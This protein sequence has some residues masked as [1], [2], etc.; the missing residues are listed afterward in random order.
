MLK[1][2]LNS[3]WEEEKYM[4]GIETK[5]PG[6]A[7]K[8]IPLSWVGGDGPPR[9]CLALQLCPASLLF[10]SM[11]A[12]QRGFALASSFGFCGQMGLSSVKP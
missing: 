8:V 10:T 4:P 1:R 6:P 12:P 5:S 3:L 9:S 11:P 7:G 2:D